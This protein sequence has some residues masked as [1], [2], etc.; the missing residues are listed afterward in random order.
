MSREFKIF[1]IAIPKNVTETTY[2]AIQ[3]QAFD[4]GYSWM[5]WYRHQIH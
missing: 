3:V 4:L 1:K 5:S 2:T